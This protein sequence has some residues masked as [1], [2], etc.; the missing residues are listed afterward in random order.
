MEVLSENYRGMPR[1]WEHKAL[2]SLSVLP[3]KERWDR[4]EREPWTLSRCRTAWPL[5]GDW[6]RAGRWLSE[7]HQ[8]PFDTL[9]EKNFQYHYR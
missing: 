4:F 9:T 2:A 8:I 7:I 6:E 1:L 3:D 5:K